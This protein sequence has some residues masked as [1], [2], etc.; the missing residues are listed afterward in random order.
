M[1]EIDGQ[2][3]TMLALSRIDKGASSALDKAIRATALSIHADA[4]KSIQRG[5]KSG[6][7]YTRGARSHQASAPGQAPAS[8]TGNLASNIDYVHGRSESFVGYNGSDEYP[9]YLEF[10]TQNMA[11]RPWLRPARDKNRRMFEKRVKAAQEK[12]IEKGSRRG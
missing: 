12:V 6:V 8:D 3:E 1:M 10:G 9:T 7:V 2:K 11:E 5:T 4:V